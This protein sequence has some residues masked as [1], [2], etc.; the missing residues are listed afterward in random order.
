MSDQPLCEPVSPLHVA[1]VVVLVL[2]LAVST[3]QADAQK[4]EWIRLLTS[5]DPDERSSA[6]ISILASDDESTLRVLLDHLKP[7]RPDDVRISVIT[8]FR[9]QRDDRA[10]PQLVA[11]L[12][13]KSPQ[14]RQAAVKA[15][16]AITTLKAASLLK[17]VAADG[18]RTPEIRVQVIAI[19]GETGAIDAIETL[20]N[21]L[22]DRD[23]SVRKSARDALQQVTLRDFETI[24]EW[25]EWGK[26]RRDWTR[27]RML[28]EL[29]QSLIRRTRVLAQENDSLRKAL[30][31]QY[32]GNDPAVILPHLI[33]AI[34]AEVQ[35]LA[36]N[37]IRA[38]K[39]LDD[40]QR[41]EVVAALVQVLDDRDSS[42]R[43]AV[44]E[45]LGDLGDPAASDAL[46][47]QL[48]DPIVHVRVAA[49]TSLGKIDGPKVVAPLCGLL[50]D[51]TEDVAVAAAHS[52]GALGDLNALAPLKKAVSEPEKR[53][54][55]YV[56]AAEALTR[57]KD[58]R[59][60]PTL[61]SLLGS[62]NTTVRNA[63]VDA[64]GEHAAKEAVLPLSKLASE[65]T[66]PQIRE[67]ALA[68][69]AKI[70]D[71]AGLDAVIKAF[72]DKEKRVAEKA[73][74]YLDALAK[75][76]VAVYG[77]AV[78]RLADAR[79]F[80]LVNEVL[81]R[82]EAQLG[83]KTPNLPNELVSLRHRAARRFMSAQAWNEAKPFLEKLRAARPKDP[84]YVV[85]LITCL[86]NL[87]DHDTL[88]TLLSQARS[89]MPD[90]RG[91]WW[92]ETVKVIEEIG[93][94][95][96]CVIKLVD[97]F[98]KED[99][100]LGGPATAKRLNELRRKAK[101]KLGLLPA[102]PAPKAPAKTNAKP[103]PPQPKEPP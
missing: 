88:L 63:V 58:P 1:F 36:V 5:T 89:T 60:V 75:G 53:P 73:F 17:Q 92:A 47:A 14:V 7:V 100:K 16:K 61:I 11:C 67:G 40:K 31:N 6:A 43:A 49:A 30:L 8:A 96:K 28:E 26:E 9:V 91:E 65:D 52:L 72:T 78:D 45:A 3:A 102:K 62:P 54:K 41:K 66:N 19:L 20:I 57:I 81:K 35:M 99:P 2:S 55:L 37:K 97:E 94:D 77:T 98:E 13:D 50:S 48:N 51:P 69:L 22:S 25:Q 10:T 68:A 4:H 32:A 39:K 80:A 76:K 70:G 27:E 74:Q 64:L 21:L 29:A 79:Q 84:T 46:I 15:L 12:D 103:T 23:E 42:V 101:E 82:A 85:D 44:A 83:N 34:S 90:Q 33:K 56:A 59:V 86:R 24:P 93:G 71:L 18:N 87:K 95:A 38:L